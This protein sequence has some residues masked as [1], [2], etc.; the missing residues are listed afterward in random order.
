MDARLT[1][2]V[3][4]VDEEAEIRLFWAE[5][6]IVLLQLRKWHWYRLNRVKLAIVFLEAPY[7]LKN[8]HKY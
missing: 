4:L 1:S 6:K 8:Q 3:G 2:I 7:L 5:R